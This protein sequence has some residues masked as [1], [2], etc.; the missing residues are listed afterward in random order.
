MYTNEAGFSTPLSGWAYSGSVSLPGF[1]NRFL[2]ESTVWRWLSL[3]L[4][5]TVQESDLREKG[6]LE[7]STLQRPLSGAHGHA[8]PSLAGLEHQRWC[9]KQRIC[10]T[11]CRP[12]P[13]SDSLHSLWEQ[14]CRNVPF[15]LPGWRLCSFRTNVQRGLVQKAVSK[16]DPWG[17]K[18]EPR[19]PNHQLVG[20]L[21]GKLKGKCEEE[22][23]WRTHDSGM[24]H[25]SSSW[26]NF[27][28]V[29]FLLVPL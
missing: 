22:S 2:E 19:Y 12:R 29:S 6:R 17:K 13:H 5:W 27:T 7:P 1:S 21:A 14:E 20:Y 4:T 18:K 25:I 10:V 26:F 23:Q 24:P 15:S 16:S 9:V 8:A 3:G 11:G 28:T